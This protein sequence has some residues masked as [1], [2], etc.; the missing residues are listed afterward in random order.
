[1]SH[2]RAAGLPLDHIAAEITAIP[3]ATEESLHWGQSALTADM[4]GPM[5]RLWRASEQRILGG[6]PAFSVDEVVSIRDAVW[7]PQTVRARPGEPV[8]LLSYLRSVSASLLEPRG[9]VA[10]PARRQPAQEEDQKT[11]LT[12]RRAWRWMS[13][14]L[15]PDLLIAGLRRGGE[16][17]ERVAVLS[18]VLERTLNESGY[19]E[20][21]LHLGAALDFATLWA[22]VQYR[23]ADSELKSNAFGGAGGVLDE[24]QKLGPWLLRAA[25]ARYTLAAFLATPRRA[26][27]AT[28]LWTVFRDQLID[29][30]GLLTFDA[31]LKAMRE[32]RTA[33]VDDARF[34]WLVGAYQQLTGIR[35][36]AAPEN[37]SDVAQLDPIAHLFGL[38]RVSTGRLSTELLFMDHAFAYMESAPRD[39]VFT[40]LFWQVVRVRGCLYRH[41]VQRPMTRGLQWFVRAYERAKGAR[42]NLGRRD[43][44][45]LL[46]SA[47]AI[48]G[49]GQRSI[50][51][52]LGPPD[53]VS[54]ALDELKQLDPFESSKTR[55]KRAACDRASDTADED[56]FCPR[57]EVAV[58][59]HF[60]KL[61]GGGASEGLP[62]ANWGETNANPGYS[63]NVSQY[64]FSAFYGAARQQAIALGELFLRF[65]VSL[66][67]VRAV[68]VCTDEMG[69]PTWV[70]APLVRYVRAAA[71][72]AAM[73][74]F[75][76][77]RRDLPPF[78]A[79]AHAGEDFVHLLS[80]LRSVDEAIEGL[81]LGPGD[82]IGHGLALGVNPTAW[83]K[84]AGRLPIL[85]EERLFD[86]VWLWQWSTRSG[87]QRIGGNEVENEIGLHSEEMFGTSRQPRE[88]VKLMAQLFDSNLLRRSGF[89]HGRPGTS[90]G[91]TP[92][93]GRP[94]YESR[95][96]LEIYLTDR[97]FF[98]RSHELVWIDPEREAPSLCHLQAEAGE[99]L[100][101]PG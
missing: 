84:R 78:R 60:V 38:G 32:L 23:L 57:P 30:A 94:P 87:G 53:S 73:A 101:G 67:L 8:P 88:I 81:Q 17:P 25:I 28:T 26:D 65:P 80:G 24:G 39:E 18:P 99:K 9:Q 31:L 15:P 54:A 16:G 34:A 100:A 41:V 64:R 6:F 10:I 61:R 92:T 33:S 1:M 4:K 21:H 13:F 96:D 89:P 66:E 42:S 46:Q 68:D 85:R 47:L 29:K 7:F 44:A 49:A 74:I 86:L 98:E 83:A 20:T 90:D 14:A 58:V 43:R 22:I 76:R 45:I 70:F 12:A 27:F 51:V 48:G 77:T 63:K 69:V 91:R 36:V 3:F 93:A 5:G 19:A 2:L 59:Y 40:A 82:R 35:A 97:A 72:R 52:R 55:A 56:A 79:T 37:L 62:Q 95:E 50:E 11:E 75:S 71:D